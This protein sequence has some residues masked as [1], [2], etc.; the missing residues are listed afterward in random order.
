M[1]QSANVFTMT[2]LS[3]VPHWKAPEMEWGRLCRQGG[4]CNCDDENVSC[5]V[6]LQGNEF[7][8][9]YDSVKFMSLLICFISRLRIFGIIR[10]YKKE[11]NISPLPL[12]WSQHKIESL[13]IILESDLLSVFPDRIGWF[14]SRLLII[15]FKEILKNGDLNVALKTS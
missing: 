3:S 12:T 8:L 7:R 14:F 11:A 1:I 10:N 6:R 9:I 13:K 5:D 15:I 4:Y 2:C